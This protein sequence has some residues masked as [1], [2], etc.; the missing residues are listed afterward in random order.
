M[1]ISSVTVWERTSW[2]DERHA[3]PNRRESPVVT[4]EAETAREKGFVSLTRPRSTIDLNNAVTAMQDTI[5]AL[6]PLVRSLARSLTCYSVRAAR[7]RTLDLTRGQPGDGHSNTRVVLR[8]RAHSAM[9][10]KPSAVKRLRK[11]ELF[12]PVHTRWRRGINKI[13]SIPKCE[14]N[15]GAECQLKLL[16]SNS[17]SLIAIEHL[18]LNIFYR[19]LNIF[20]SLS[21]NVIC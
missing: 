6:R 20:F 10:G 18:P 16:L 11:T 14:M 21:L 8:W 5:D 15:V 7:Q 1:K 19:T 4:P 12:P 9:L 2:Q 3:A 13:T 17:D